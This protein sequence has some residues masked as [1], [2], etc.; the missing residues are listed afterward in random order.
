MEYSLF[1]PPFGIIIALSIY[2]SRKE[3]IPMRGQWYA[4]PLAVGTYAAWRLWRASAMLNL[5]DKVAI[6]TGGSRGLGFLLAKELADGGARVALCARS[7]PELEKAKSRLVES[8]ACV[9][10]FPCNVAV[11]K[12]V[13]EFVGHVLDKFGGIDLLINNAG[14]MSVGPLA[15]QTDKDFQEAMDVMFW[16]AFNF[17]MAVLPHMRGKRSGRIANITS[18]GGKVSVPHLLPYSAAKFALMGFSEGLRAELRKDG[19]LVTTVV[20]GLMRT[21][22]YVNAQFRGFQNAEFSWF[23]AAAAT[24]LLAMDAKRA[25]RKIVRAVREGIAELTL[26]PQARLAALAEGLSPGLT[27]EMLGLVNRLLPPPDGCDVARR[28]T[29]LPGPSPTSLFGRLIGLG[30]GAV[31]EFLESKQDKNQKE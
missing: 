30:R 12:E 20:P 22:S 5:R 19:I 9:F 10:A 29:E 3:V 2:I 24:P 27:A 28:G 15:S 14:I 25:A 11:K 7:E 16:G 13:D 1:F 6:V 8:G 18:I 31:K 17:I 4:G 21:G 26:T 23:G